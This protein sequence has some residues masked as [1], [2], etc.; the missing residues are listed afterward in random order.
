VSQLIR[1]LAGK[2]AEGGLDRAALELA[3]IE[4]PDLDVEN[5]VLL[6]DSHARELRARVSTYTDGTEFLD[7]FAAYFNELGFHGDR[8]DYYHP[9]NSCLNHAL[10]MR[11]GLPITLSVVYCEIARRLNRPVHGIGLPGHFLVCY[12]DDG[13]S[14]IVD[15]FHECRLLSPDDCRELAL[16]S[17]GVD[18]TKSPECLNPVSN[19]TILMRMLNN[20]RVAYYREQNLWKVSRVLDLLLVAEP[21]SVPLLEERERLRGYLHE[22]H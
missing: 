11:T 15:V 4:Y 21:A 14:A 10:L 22:V 16:E 12:E 19:R 5:F 13:I 7:T 8:E 1:I 17:A 18:I 3:A 20:L 9:R 2:G 6:L